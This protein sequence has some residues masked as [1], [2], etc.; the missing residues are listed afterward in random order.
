MR[1]IRTLMSVAF[2]VYRFVLCTLF[3]VHRANV[4]SVKYEKRTLMDAR[5]KL[6]RRVYR[7]RHFKCAVCDKEWTRIDFRRVAYDYQ[8]PARLFGR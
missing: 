7:T 6:I 4:Q 5:S 8:Y 2:I 1:L 3:R